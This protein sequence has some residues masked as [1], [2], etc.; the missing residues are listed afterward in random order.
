MS[1]TAPTDLQALITAKEA[2][3]GTNDV[4]SILAVF[5]ENP[6]FEFYPTRRRIAGRE[7]VRRFYEQMLANFVPRLEGYRALQVFWS[8]TGMAMEE[9]LTVR[10]DGGRTQVHQFM[11]ITGVSDGRLW[12]ERL[13]G[14]EAFFR[15][16]LGDLY[17]QAEPIT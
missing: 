2:A 8:D 15:Q 1:I 5:C 3:E 13:Y 4:D 11:V 10:L 7:N 12:G 9:E 17:D 6:V 16:L 14:D